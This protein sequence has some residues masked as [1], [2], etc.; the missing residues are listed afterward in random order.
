[1][2]KKIYEEINKI[3]FANSTISI[4]NGFVG[5]NPVALSEATVAITRFLA[6]IMAVLMVTRAVED[7]RAVVV[8][9]TLGVQYVSGFEYVVTG[10]KI[11]NTDATGA[12]STRRQQ[13]ELDIEGYN[14]MIQAKHDLEDAKKAFQSAMVF[15]AIQIVLSVALA[16]ASAYLSTQQAPVTGGPPGAHL[17]NAQLLVV[18]LYVA[19]FLVGAMKHLSDLRLAQEKVNRE[20]FGDVEKANVLLMA[21]FDKLYL[22]KEE[23]PVIRQVKKALKSMNLSLVESSAN[24]MITLNSGYLAELQYLVAEIFEHQ[25]AILEALQALAEARDIVR[26][27]TWRIP[28]TSERFAEAR[29]VNQLWNQALNQL[30]QISATNIGDYITRYNARVQAELNLAVL[31]AKIMVQMVFEGLNLA[32]SIVS[33]FKG[34]T[35]QVGLALLMNQKGDFY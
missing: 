10:V 23:D 25:N 6:A 29:V 1:L 30:L 31:T 19:K 26:G 24:G 8:A 3:S 28:A 12:L 18:S 32:G 5:I 33:M 13:L 7:I 9:L 16:F 21:Y 27:M 34:P 35:N 11:L 15:G 2:E 20:K 4:G 22:G 17:R 14:R